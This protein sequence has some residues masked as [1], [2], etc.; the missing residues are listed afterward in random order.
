MIIFPSKVIN[1][2]VRFRANSLLCPNYSYRYF[3]YSPIFC[4]YYGRAVSWEYFALP[5]ALIGYME[6]ENGHFL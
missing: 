3:I 5:L 6:E 4:I 2:P 1:F